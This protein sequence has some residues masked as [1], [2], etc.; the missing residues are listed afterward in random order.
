MFSV[1]H[2]VNYNTLFARWSEANFGDN[3]DAFALD[4]ESLYDYL[5]QQG[6]NFELLIDED[7]LEAS[8]GVFN[9]D[10]VRYLFK[11]AV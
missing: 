1:V 6:C 3:E 4:I 11:Q 8:N 9:A 10:E 2:I 7:A 5:Y